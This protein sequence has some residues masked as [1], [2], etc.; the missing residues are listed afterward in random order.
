MSRAASV[1]LS[2]SEWTPAAEPAWRTRVPRIV[3]GALVCIAVLC[4]LAAV[5]AVFRSGVQ[6]VREFIDLVLFPAPANLGYAAFLLVMAGAL[7]R[8]KR[9]AYWIL[10]LVL[11]LQLLL[12]V[13]VLLI[14]LVVPWESGAVEDVVPSWVRWSLGANVVLTAT[15]M[16][17]LGLA[18]RQFYGRV[19]RASVPKALGTFVGLVAVFIALG[20]GLVGVFPGSLHDS[21]D[22]LSWTVERVLGGAVTLDITRTGEAPG[23]VNLVLG[24]FG[25]AT[26]FAT[27]AVLFRSQRTASV[28]PAADE[29]Q[30][31]ALLAEHGEVDSLGYFATRRDKA[32]LFS[33]SGKAAVSYRVVAGVCLASGDP[34]GDPEAWGPA[35]ER[36]LGMCRDYTWRPAVIGVGERGAH[37]YARAGLKILRLGDEAVLELATFNLEGREMRPVRQ[38]VNRLHRAGYRVRV[39]RQEEVSAEEMAEVAG[40]AAQWGQRHRTRFL[41]GVGPVGRSHRWSMRAGRGRER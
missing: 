23:W 6:P 13:L 17:V 36:W 19:Q 24:L 37:A 10:L 22:R 39:R 38:A 34:L 21:A 14:I 4:A 25:M 16:V 15:V 11:S 35:I 32:V 27:L 5:G 2:R 7:G 9:I 26:L 20:Y 29:R 1:G 18:S 3:V 28:L 41:D 40:R 33:A 8:R 31:R 30:V 12:S